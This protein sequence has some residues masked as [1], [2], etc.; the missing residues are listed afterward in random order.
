MEASVGEQNEWT[1]FYFIPPCGSW[2]RKIRFFATISPW[3]DTVIGGRTA[4]SH[5][6]IQEQWGQRW[7]LYDN[8]ED[9]SW[10]SDQSLLD[11][12]CLNTGRLPHNHHRKRNYHPQRQVIY[13]LSF[14]EGRTWMA[15]TAPFKPLL[16][17]WVSLW[18]LLTKEPDTL[19]G[20]IIWQADKFC[21]KRVHFWRPDSTAIRRQLPMFSA[22]FELLLICFVFWPIQRRHWFLVCASTLAH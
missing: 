12:N 22:A 2:L 13:P 14:Q 21:L 3:H 16:H 17:W 5:E 20:D 1:P 4:E 8:K 9:W 7:W 19:Q 11:Q 6:A 18:L 15:D 10:F